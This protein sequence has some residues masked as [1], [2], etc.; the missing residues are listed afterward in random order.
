MK[1][2]RF[3]AALGGAA[4]AWPVSARAQPAK[5]P[6]IGF[7][8]S[9]S[10]VEMQLMGF[11]RGLGETGYVEGR[12]VAIAYR[13]ADGVYDR[14]PA[15]T[16]DLVSRQVAVIVAQ[17]APAARAAKAGTTTIP[18]VF[19]VGIDPVAEGL[20]ASLARPGGN[21]TGV[22]LLATDL[23]AKRFSLMSELA[24][25]ARHFALIVNPNVPNPWIESVAEDA[26][27]TK[28][29]LLVL[30]AA[31]VGEI[32]AAF[33]TMVQ[34]RVDALVIGADTFLDGVPRIA[35]LA[36]RHRIPAMGNQRRFAEQGGL[37]TYGVSVTDAYRQIGA[38]AGQI[39][40]GAKPA[41]LPVRRPTKFELVLNLKTANAL[42]LAIPTAL[43]V[44]AEE[45]IE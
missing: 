22:T 37:V 4:A 9:N 12:T 30:K 26:R 29:R 2:R 27:A 10:A 7:L 43:L 8:G 45:V 31:T 42:G 39:L 18:I 1:R 41:D 32:D 20:V 38:Y 6:V 24:P 40:R 17:A 15:M 35:A 14:L 44:Q 3:I 5:M 25:Q 21:L 34:E 28:V 33:A 19:G 11:R 13:M 36:L 16:A 23:M